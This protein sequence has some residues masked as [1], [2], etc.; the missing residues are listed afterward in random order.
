MSRRVLTLACGEYD[1]TRALADG[2]IRPAGFELRYV[3]LN[4]GELFARMVRDREFDVSEMS[5][6]TYL[7]LRARGD[8]GLVG[9]PVFPSRVFR[10][11]YIFVNR[12]AGIGRPEDL[13]GRRVGTMQWQLTSSLWLRGT[14]ADEHGVQPSSITWLV[15]GQDEPGQHERAPVDVPPEVRVE[16]IPPG[17]SLGGLLVEGAIDAIFAPHVPRVFRDGDPRVVRLFPDFR[18]VETDYFRRTGLFPIMHLVVVRRDVHEANPSL[19]AGLLAAFCA[20]KARA[21]DRLRFTGTLATMVP[22]LVAEFEAAEALFGARYWP[23]G[24]DA[25]RPELETAIRYAVEQG[26]ARRSLT[27]EELFAPETLDMVDEVN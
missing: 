6:S 3:A 17:T 25:N 27:V 7:N 16:A 12:D 5:L 9:I 2:S 4:P 21:M 11:G 10:H 14:L 22:W 20:A 23:Y 13:A 15:G 1:R 26:I 24:V 19:A 8:D 18:A